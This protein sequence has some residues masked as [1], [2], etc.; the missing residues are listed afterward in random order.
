MKRDLDLM[1]EIMLTLEEKMEYGKN[2]MSDRLF[3]MMNNKTLSSA[4]L[5]Y[6][7]GLL[8]EVNFIDAVKT[9]HHRGIDFDI[10]TITSDGQDFLDTIRQDS[11][12]DI[13][14]EQAVK[15]GGYSL[16]LIVDI[17]KEYLK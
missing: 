12:W 1:R 14:K 7:I 15:M 9:S 3:E 4:K 16:S 10:T 2:I 13:I 6:H 17:G 8:I 5:S 11:T